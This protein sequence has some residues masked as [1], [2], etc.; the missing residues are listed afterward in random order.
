MSVLVLGVGNVLLTDEG[1]GVHAVEALERRYLC[2]PGVAILDGG[3]AGLEL[4]GHIRLQDQ[5]ILIDAL[6]GGEP[7]GT[8]TRLAGEA[9]PKVFLTR[10][11][12]HQLGISDVLAAATLAGEL[13]GRIVLFGVEPAD[14]SPGLGLS[15]PVLAAMPELLSAVRSELAGQGLPLVPRLE[16]RPAGASLWSLNL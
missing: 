11:S 1:V 4:L 7:P 9:V 12:P 14:L 2:P 6:T 13:P 5:L 8:V 3:T 15:P 10:I 16:P